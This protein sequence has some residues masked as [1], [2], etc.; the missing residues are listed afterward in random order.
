[1]AKFDTRLLDS[2]PLAPDAKSNMVILSYA[3]LQTRPYWQELALTAVPVYDIMVAVKG[4]YGPVF[5]G[6]TW[7]GKYDSN[8]EFT[9]SNPDKLIARYFLDFNEEAVREQQKNHWDGSN[10][11]YLDP[12]PHLE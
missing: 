12:I 7:L 2:H 1:M 11:E 10:E 4:Q 8:G 9:A 6:E 3:D 5:V